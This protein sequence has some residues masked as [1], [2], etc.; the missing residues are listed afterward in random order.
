[1]EVSIWKV[2]L[3]SLLLEGGR[4]GE[5]E[6]VVCCLSPVGTKNA[7]RTL[8]CCSRHLLHCTSSFTVSPPAEPWAALALPLHQICISSEQGHFESGVAWCV[9]A[10]FDFF[11]LF[12]N[13]GNILG[14]NET[15]PFPKCIKKKRER[16]KKKRHC[17]G[18]PLR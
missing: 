16:G 3:N 6:R 11:S 7:L 17:T 13:L 2:F 9:G 18:G 5:K 12:F 1:M 8:P 4:G 14:I 15:G 10:L